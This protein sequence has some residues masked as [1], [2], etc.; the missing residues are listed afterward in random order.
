MSGKERLTAQQKQRSDWAQAQKEERNRAEQQLRYSDYL[1][2]VCFL[3][4]RSI[5]LVLLLEN[6]MKYD[7]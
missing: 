3:M 6:S 7:L 2:E 1:Y 5:W 4:M